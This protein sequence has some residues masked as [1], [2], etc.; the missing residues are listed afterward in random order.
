MEYDAAFLEE[1]DEVSFLNVGGTESQS[2][3][4]SGNVPHPSFCKNAVKDWQQTSELGD[5]FNYCL[6]RL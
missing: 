6:D 4:L 5:L 1:Y 2:A 3:S